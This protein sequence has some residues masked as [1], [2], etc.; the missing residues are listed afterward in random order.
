MNVYLGTLERV[1]IDLKSTTV[2]E[3]RL[4]GPRHPESADLAVSLT[5][6]V[7]N[8]QQTFFSSS[9]VYLVSVHLVSVQQVLWRLLTSSCSSNRSS[10]RFTCDTVM[11]TASFPLCG[12]CG[13]S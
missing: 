3:A 12:C 1:S 10:M 5:S 9:L 4:K 11:C 8:N 2:A 7:V 13:D 6:L